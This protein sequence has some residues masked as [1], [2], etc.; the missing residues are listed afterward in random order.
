MHISRTLWKAA[1]ALEEK[2]ILSTFFGYEIMI[3]WE[4]RETLA[5]VYYDS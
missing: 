3:F 2:E 1:S 5:K 4:N